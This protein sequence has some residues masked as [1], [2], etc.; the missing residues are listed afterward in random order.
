MS[1]NYDWIYGMTPLGVRDVLQRSYNY[2]LFILYYI[3][4]LTKQYTKCTSY[5]KY[6]DYAHGNISTGV[7][8]KNIKHYLRCKDKAEKSYAQ[9]LFKSRFPTS[10]QTYR[11]QVVNPRHQTP[12]GQSVAKPEIPCRVSYVSTLVWHKGIRWFHSESDIL[13]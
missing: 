13:I 2:V 1:I 10:G 8:D 12:Q 9:L 6:K 4:H 5:K 3:I 7:L 11:T